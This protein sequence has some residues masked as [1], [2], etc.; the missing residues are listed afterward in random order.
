MS[1][2]DVWRA[3][4]VDGAD[5]LRA[6][7]VPHV[8]VERDGEAAQV[9]VLVGDRVLALHGVTTMSTGFLVGEHQPVMGRGPPGG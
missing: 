6:G 5:P 7:R 1:R 8:L 9:H 4:L 2:S 3:P